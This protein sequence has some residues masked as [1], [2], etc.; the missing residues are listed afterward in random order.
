MSGNSRQRRRSVRH[1]KHIIHL[2]NVRPGSLHAEILRTCLEEQFGRKG[3]G[4]R[5]GMHIQRQDNWYSELYVAF[6][7]G[8]DATWFLTKWA[9]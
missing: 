4:R 7:Y 2:D 3:Y 9:K 8:K 5:W 1:W 6:H